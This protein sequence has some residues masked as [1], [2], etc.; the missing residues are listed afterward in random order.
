MGQIRTRDQGPAGTTGPILETR[1][2]ILDS[3]KDSINFVGSQALEAARRGGFREAIVDHIGLAVHEIMTN[4]VIHGNRGNLHKKVVVTI[5]RTPNKLKI[6]IADEGDGFDPDH[7]P[8]PLSPEGLL[9]GSGR[10]V[11]LARAFMDEFYVLREPLGWT[12]VI[13]AKSVH[14]AV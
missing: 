5:S 9:K 11:Y 7:L 1:T 8:D 14:S 6:E 10:G 4:A 3:T 12:T 2:R 13:M